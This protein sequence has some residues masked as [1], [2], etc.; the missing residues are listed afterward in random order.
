MKIQIM[1][2]DDHPVVR[3]GITEML[4]LWDDFEVIREAGSI[5]EATRALDSGVNPSVIMLDLNLRNGSGLEWIKNRAALGRLPTVLV[6]SVNDE[7]V[8][9]ERCLRAGARGYI[10]KDAP[11]ED[12]ATA[13]RKVHSGEIA[14]SSGI[15]SKLI[16]YQHPPTRNN[17]PLNR[18]LSLLSDREMEIYQQLGT[19][20]NTKEIADLLHISPK[21][22]ETHRIHIIDKLNLTGAVELV[23]HATAWQESQ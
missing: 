9:A 17:E 2:V 10:M 23:R 1:I 19:G 11:A 4:G 22:V 18:S 20:K 13:I 6:M 21:T 16:A 5:L 14:V 15:A 3:K 12:I 7:E 8:Y